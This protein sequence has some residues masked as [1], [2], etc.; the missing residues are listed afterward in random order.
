M[1][2]WELNRLSAPMAKS[3]AIGGDFHPVVTN[4]RL[5]RP[6]PQGRPIL[7]LPDT[8]VL[9]PVIVIQIPGGAATLV[10]DI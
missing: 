4:R 1:R 8:G 3:S 2:K 7:V 9:I 5:V 6:G 10:P